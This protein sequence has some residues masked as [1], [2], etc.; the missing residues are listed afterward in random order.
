MGVFDEVAIKILL[1]YLN[2]W[3]AEYPFGPIILLFYI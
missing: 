1:Y 3:S 2:L